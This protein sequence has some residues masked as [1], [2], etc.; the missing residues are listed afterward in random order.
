MYFGTGG[1]TRTLKVIH[2]R[3]LNPLRLPV[4]PPRQGGWSIASSHRFGKSSLTPGGLSGNLARRNHWIQ[5]GAQKNQS[6]G[7]RM[8]LSDFDYDLPPELIAQYPATSRSES[9]LLALTSSGALEER[10]F[11]SIGD[12]LRRGDLL[13]VNDTKVLPAR[14][15]ARKPTG[16]RV[17]VL[18][19]RVLGDREL[20]VQMRASKTPK[21]G[22][23]LIFPDGESAHVI[24]R[25]GDFYQLRFSQHSPMEVL[26]NH[27]AV[28]L[29]PYIHREADDQDTERY[30]TVYASHPGAVA[31]P[32]A[33]LHFDQALLNQLEDRGINIGRIT[34]HVG[35]GT[36]LPVR[37]EEVADH[38]MHPEWMEVEASLCDEVR[39][40]RER[41]GRVIAVGTTTVRALETASQGGGLS[42]FQGESEIFIFPG[43][44]FSV[45]DALITNFH[46]PRTTLLMMISA[47][48]GRQRVLEAYRHAVDNKFRFY[49]YGDA[50]YIE[51]KQ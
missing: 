15:V 33:G 26:V 27:G 37:N 44:A 39:T 7:R 22:G 23:E 28:P 5:S 25:E 30:Q 19:E 10:R 34:L 12:F 17:E 14:L 3:I 46:L 35:A 13:V 4:P 21:V 11:F 48:A 42:P 51:R 49:S 38:R 36:F 45:V 18:V 41:G 6:T 16:G 20:K 50:M 2:R 1:G 47:F 40:T 8:K 31:A 24:E 9:R 32:T 29:P 43:F